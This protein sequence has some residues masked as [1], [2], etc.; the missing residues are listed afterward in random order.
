MVKHTGGVLTDR[1]AFSVFEWGCLV[2]DDPFLL[3]DT[4]MADEEEEA[5]W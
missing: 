4:S 3:M 2:D 1:T 5:F